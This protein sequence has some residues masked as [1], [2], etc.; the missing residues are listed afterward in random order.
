VGIMPTE[1][2]DLLDQ[3][4]RAGWSIGGVAFHD[5]VGGL[6]WLV[7]ATNGE[8]RV[9]ARGAT[10]AEAWRRAVEQARELGMDGTAR[11]VNASFHTDDAR[12]R[13]QKCPFAHRKKPDS[14]GSELLQSCD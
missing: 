1:D 13:P 6:V 7:S 5:G 12:S 14:D 8:N 10:C 11:R 9:V 4:R 2:V 3:L